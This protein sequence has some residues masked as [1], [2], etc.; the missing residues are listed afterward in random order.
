MNKEH[1]IRP[2]QLLLRPLLQS[3]VQA[4]KTV[5]LSGLQL[6]PLSFG[7]SFEEENVHSDAFFARRLEQVNG[8]VVFGAFN[9]STLLGTAG[10]FRHER[11]AER[12]RGT[13]WGVYVMPEAR[14][15]QLGWALVERIV[16]HAAR[17]VDILDAKV[18]TTNDVAKQI[19]SALSFKTYGVEVK[20]L[21]MQG[22]YL[23]QDLLF[24]DFTDPLR[25]QRES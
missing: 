10:M 24:I 17:H 3:D 4:Y 18:V 20:S 14:G 2:E 11:K 19:Y 7:T 13:L 23:D 16:D 1:D 21:F 25:K 6:S 22:Q 9:G 15:H 5:R 12:H 8:N